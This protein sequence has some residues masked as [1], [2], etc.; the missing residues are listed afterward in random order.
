VASY[1]WTKSIGA[2]A[3]AIAPAV[4]LTSGVIVSR[5][6]PLLAVLFTL[7]TAGLLVWDL[8]RPDRFWRVMLTP[9]PRSWL[10]LGA[11]IL[12]LYGVVSG[13]M[14]L[15]GIAGA[16]G[17]VQVLLWPAALLGVGAA[18]YS[19]FLFGQ[20]EGRD[21]W[22]SPLLFWQLLA[23]AG[24]GGAAALLPVLMFTRNDARLTASLTGILLVSVVV[25]GVITLLE[26]VASHGNKDVAAAARVLRRGPLAGRFW[27][28][29]IGLGVVAPVALLLASYA[30]PSL[31]KPLVLGAS[32]LAL[33][34]LWLYEDAWVSAGQ[35]VPM[36]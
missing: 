14:L 36:S 10:V 6:A 31:A 4:L 20:A 7:I 28:G 18:V 3:L 1:L 8:K 16:D 9:N 23:A 26:V 15:A 34:G 29:W 30:S 12:V 25:A 24:I 19:A 22:Q 21:F 17:W 11:Y 5:V 32:A 2:G 27:L 35:S 13:L 33:V